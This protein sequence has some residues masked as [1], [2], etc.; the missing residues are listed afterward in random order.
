MDA[1]EATLGIASELLYTFQHEGSQLGREVMQI[2]YIYSARKEYSFRSA[3]LSFPKNLG[4][5]PLGNHVHAHDRAICDYFHGPQASRF[6]C[7]IL[8]VMKWKTMVRPTE[9]EYV[10]VQ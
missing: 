9:E 7:T 10:C 4:R 1:S 8:S 6:L 3:I 2:S 5:Q